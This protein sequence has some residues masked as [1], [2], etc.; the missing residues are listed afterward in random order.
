MGP[1]VSGTPV[2]FTDKEALAAPFQQLE[3]NL[4]KK[5]SVG[6][7]S[8]PQIRTSEQQLNA[9]YGEIQDLEYSPE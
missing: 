6:A 9:L 2:P 3:S 8:D 7:F 5:L 1:P 4:M